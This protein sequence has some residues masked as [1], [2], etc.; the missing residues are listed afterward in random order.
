V[1]TQII[2]LEALEAPTALGALVVAR[3]MLAAGP[4]RLEIHL[5]VVAPTHLQKGRNELENKNG[6]KLSHTHTLPF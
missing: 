3:E 5:V 4:Q 6:K 2:Q 1:E